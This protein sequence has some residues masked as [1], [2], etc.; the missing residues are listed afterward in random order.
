LFATLCA[1]SVAGTCPLPPECCARAEHVAQ[2]TAWKAPGFVLRQLT[3]LRMFKAISYSSYYLLSNAQRTFGG[4]G[5][6]PYAL[7]GYGHSGHWG[8]HSV[9]TCC[10]CATPPSPFTAAAPCCVWRGRRMPRRLPHHPQRLPCPL[11]HEEGSQGRCAVNTLSRLGRDN[12]RACHWRAC[13][14][15]AGGCCLTVRKARARACW[16]LQPYVYLASPRLATRRD[17]G[18]HLFA[19][20]TALFAVRPHPHPLRCSDSTTCATAYGWVWRE[21]SGWESTYSCWGVGF[22]VKCV[23]FHV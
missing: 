10:A 17:E 12:V 14:E 4:D 5:Y 3:S 8:S 16:V 2:C 22:C 18:D 6:W 9:G 13:F 21:V 23:G 1:F 11:P 20:G 19:A 15:R 7:G